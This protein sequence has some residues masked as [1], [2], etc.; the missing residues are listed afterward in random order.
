MDLWNWTSK[1]LGKIDSKIHTY[2][3]LIK[4]PFKYLLEKQQFNF[5]TII[6]LIFGCRPLKL[7][8]DFWRPFDIPFQRQIFDT[9]AHSPNTLQEMYRNVV[10]APTGN[11]RE[12]IHIFTYIYIH[13]FFV[14]NIFSNDPTIKYDPSNPIQ[15]EQI[16]PCMYLYIYIDLHLFMHYIIHICLSL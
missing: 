11:E 1:D 16:D 2:A 10:L 13:I 4:S 7:N 5:R 6:H 8:W 14:T 12:A 3:N 15:S 9:L